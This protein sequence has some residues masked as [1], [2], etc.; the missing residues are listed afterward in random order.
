MRDNV[1]H[2]MA[3]EPR[4]HQMSIRIPLRI[5]EALNAQAKQERRSASDVINKL[6]EGCYPP[7]ASNEEMAEGDRQLRFSIDIT[8][9]HLPMA[10]FL[11]DSDG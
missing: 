1:T 7:R 2:A 4:D 11:E 10:S 3:Q 6:L 9:D 5:R 8:G